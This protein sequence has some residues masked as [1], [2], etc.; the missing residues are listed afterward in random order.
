MFDLEVVLRPAAA[1][2]ENNQ[3][4]VGLRAAAAIVVV[5]VPSPSDSSLHSEVA[6]RIDSYA[7]WSCSEKDRQIG[8]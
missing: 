4:W 2:V 5:V 1:V 8:P 3:R 6:F 7:R